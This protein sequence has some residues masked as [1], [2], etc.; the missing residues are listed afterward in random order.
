[1]TCYVLRVTDARAALARLPKDP[2][3][4]A[5]VDVAAALDALGKRD[6]AVAMFKRR[7]TARSV[8]LD[9]RSCCTVRWFAQGPAR[10]ATL[11]EDRGALMPDPFVVR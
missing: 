1:M 7:R 9:R 2:A 11:R 5:S 3:L 6:A 4:A 8:D 10:C